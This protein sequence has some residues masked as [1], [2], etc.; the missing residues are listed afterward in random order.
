ML[1]HPTKQISIN[2]K[3]ICEE[4]IKE[5]NLKTIS[6]SLLPKVIE[7][8]SEIFLSSQCVCAQ[9]IEFMCLLKLYNGDIQRKCKT[10]ILIINIKLFLRVFPPY[11]YMGK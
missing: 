4:N 3:I 8:S 10:E 9:V 7:E 5:L 1:C 11:I 6:K 2:Q